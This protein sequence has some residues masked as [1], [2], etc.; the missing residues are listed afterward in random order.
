MAQALVHELNEMR[1]VLGEHL[2]A[3]LEGQPLRAV[4]AVIGCM[5]GGLVTQEVDVDIV[6]HD[7]LQQV[8]DVAVIGDGNRRLRLKMGIGHLKDMVE[9]VGALMHPALV[10]SRLDTRLVDLGDDADSTRDLG[11]LRLG[12]AHAAEARAHEEMAREVAVL[13]HAEVLAARVQERIVR[14]VHD[15]LRADVHPAARRHLAVIGDAHFLG[16]FPV[17]LVVELADHERIRDDHARRRRLGFKEAQRVAGLHDQ[18]LVI[19]HDFQVLFDETVLHPVLADAARLAVGDELVG[20]EAN[21]E[22]EVI[23]NHDLK[24]L[25]LDAVALVLVNGLAVDAACGTEAV[26]ID[27]AAGRELLQEL[28]DEFFMQA[29]VHIAQ[30]IFQRRL[31][32]GRRQMETARRRTADARHEL[33]HR[34]QFLDRLNGKNL[35]THGIKLPFS[36]FDFILWRFTPPDRPWFL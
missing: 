36:K 35:L 22:I 3:L 1:P 15:A 17:L 18:R 30:G 25:A 12:T 24:G 31:R 16:D 34:R 11:R 10:Q 5:A 27:T 29:R 13:W 14:A 8:D 2:R 32:L 23:V 7:I 20:I 28:G 4:A 9:V 21:L 33:R 19:R 6:F 26:A